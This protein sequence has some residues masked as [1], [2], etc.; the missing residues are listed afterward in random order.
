MVKKK[1]EAWYRKT[2]KDENEMEAWL[3]RCP[4]EVAMFAKVIRLDDGWFLVF[5]P[6]TEAIH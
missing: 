5:Y 1:L 3:D 2:L 4:L 6:S